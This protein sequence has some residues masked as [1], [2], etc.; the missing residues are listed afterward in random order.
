MVN[1]FSIGD[2]LKEEFKEFEHDTQTYQLVTNVIDPES[3]YS[4]KYELYDIK[5]DKTTT[6]WCKFVD[7]GDGFKK[8]N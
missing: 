4:A 2:I 6:F 3:Y 5:N 1:K 7:F 8:V